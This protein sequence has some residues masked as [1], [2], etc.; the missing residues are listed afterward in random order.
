M[1]TKVKLIFSSIHLIR[2]SGLLHLYYESD[3][4]NSQRNVPVPVHISNV[5]LQI[6]CPT[7]PLHA[8]LSGPRSIANSS[9][10]FYSSSGPVS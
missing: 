1:S 10:N 9:G 8:H 5:I 4:M 3:C 6:C 7:K 2:A